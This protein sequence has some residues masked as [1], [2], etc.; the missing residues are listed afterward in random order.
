MANSKDDRKI[1]REL[2]YTHKEGVLE[3]IYEGQDQK[4][5][6]D[7]LKVTSD[8]EKEAMA[9]QEVVQATEMKL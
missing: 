4:K 6:K 7:Q 3:M 2:R 5:S 8:I 1:N 9:E